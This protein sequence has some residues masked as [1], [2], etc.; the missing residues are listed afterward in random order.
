MILD[1]EFRG[2][3]RVDKLNWASERLLSDDNSMQE[4]QTDFS[5][6]LFLRTE[7][8]GICFV[9]WMCLPLPKLIKHR[10][11]WCSSDGMVPTR[12]ERHFMVSEWTQYLR[13]SIYRPMTQETQMHAGINS[14]DYR[15]SVY[16]IDHF[17][18]I[19]I[20]KSSD[21]WFGGWCRDCFVTYSPIMTARPVRSRIMYKSFMM[22][23][24]SISNHQ[25][26][27]IKYAV[28]W[29]PRRSATSDGL[30]ILSL[31]FTADA[32]VPSK[33]WIQISGRASRSHFITSD[34]SNK[35]TMSP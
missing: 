19:N 33:R 3:S 8:M 27:T 6:A 26:R 35:L 25:S 12:N 17:D 16:T 1:H 21:C 10:I 15:Y 20:S 13:D 29:H 11:E 5:A 34:V 14:P 31:I 30:V 32:V 18:E 7:V 4:W 2:L 22:Y 9:F 23:D 24:N 28:N